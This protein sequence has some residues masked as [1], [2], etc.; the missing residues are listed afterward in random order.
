ML[1]LYRSGRQAE[2]LDVYQET[3]ALLVEE[4]GI[5]PSARLQELEKAILR[6]DPISSEPPS[7][8]PCRRALWSWPRRA[9]PRRAAWHRRAA[10]TPTATGVDPRAPRTRRADLASS[11]RHTRR[12]PARARSSAACRLASPPTRRPSRGP[13]PRSSPS[14]T[15]STSSSSVLRQRCSRPA[16]PIEISRSSSSA[17]CDVAMLVG[18]GR[19]QSESRGD[20]LQ[21]RRARLVGDRDRRVARR[22]AWHNPAAPGY[23]GR[24]RA[25]P[26]GREQAAGSSLLLV[27]QVIG[28]VTEPVLVPAGEEGILE[29]AGN[30]RLLVVGLSDRW[31]S[32]GLGR[33]RLA[34]AAHSSRSH[35]VRSTRPPP[36]RR[37]TTRDADPLHLDAGIATRR[38]AS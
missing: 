31:A 34:V 23:Q 22:L 2:A 14:S 13:R 38:I 4:L 28:I 33:V 29:A 35:A 20:A 9:R 24:S 1:A 36:R 3:R 6:Q 7:A 10:R 15:M 12:A 32:E 27:Q 37:R 18:P 16:G 25:R 21:R 19:L 5:E 17:P 26:A 8:A 11:D 30:A